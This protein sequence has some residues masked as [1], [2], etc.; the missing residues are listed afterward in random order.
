MC[1]LLQHKISAPFFLFLLTTVALGTLAG[2]RPKLSPPP[3]KVVEADMKMVKGC[4]YLGE[5]HGS[6]TDSMRA[7]WRS[8]AQIIEIGMENVKYQALQEAS[9][10]G[11]THVVWTSETR[12][13][14]PEITGRAYRCK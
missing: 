7:G 6:S 12:S 1:G 11:A 14:K 3:S 13:F 2:C 9:A 10:L 4:K 8:D 5:V